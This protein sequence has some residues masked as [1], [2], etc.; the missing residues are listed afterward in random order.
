MQP[1]NKQLSTQQIRIIA[2]IG[3]AIIA[4]FL[5]I[6]LFR[7]FQ[8]RI[9]STDPNLGQ[10]NSAAPYLRIKFN[11]ELDASALKLST[12]QPIVPKENIHVKGDTIQ[13]DFGFGVLQ[14]DTKYTIT[15]NKVVSKAGDTLT[16]KKIEFTTADIP[17]EK[18]SAEAQ[19]TVIDRQ[20]KYDY[21][22]ESIDVDGTENLLDFGI[23]TEQVDAMRRAVFNFGTAQDT[24]IKE[25]QIYGSSVENVPFN[26]DAEIVATPAMTF[27]MTI[28]DV[29]YAARLEFTEITKA[30]LILFNEQTG[31]Q[32]FDSGFIDSTAEE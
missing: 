18:M 15:L 16:D 2:I 8:F 23:T 25:S 17:F 27:T 20:D 5:A 12:N 32:V 14:D 1:Q 7:S 21:T 9:T 29:S 22:P 19:K 30:R 13:L 4:V 31:A 24:Q 10:I 3:I 26:P 11:R 28:N 6:S